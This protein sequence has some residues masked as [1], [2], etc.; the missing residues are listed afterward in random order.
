M[1]PLPGVLIGDHLWISRYLL[2]RVAEDFGVI[3]TFD[4]KPYMGDDW[5]G[6]GGHLNFSTEEMRQE[7]GLE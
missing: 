5:F 4:P 3:V 2:H 7:N 6:S 1:G